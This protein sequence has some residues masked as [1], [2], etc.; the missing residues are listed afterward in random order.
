MEKRNK[1][2]MGPSATRI[3]DGPPPLGARL[4]RLDAVRVPGETYK[5]PDTNGAR[6]IE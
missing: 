6:P 4:G 2:F 1:T 5:S 3:L